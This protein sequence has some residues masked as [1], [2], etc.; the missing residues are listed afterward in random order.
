LPLYVK[1][2]Y[3]Y[4]RDSRNTAAAIL[5]LTPAGDMFPTTRSRQFAHGK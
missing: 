4:V 2:L 3:R 1:P 5:N